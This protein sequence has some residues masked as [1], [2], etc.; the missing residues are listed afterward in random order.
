MEEDTLAETVCVYSLLDCNYRI[1]LSHSSFGTRHFPFL[2]LRLSF[3][4]SSRAEALSF[5]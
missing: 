5:T 3:A 4:P 1:A 2:M